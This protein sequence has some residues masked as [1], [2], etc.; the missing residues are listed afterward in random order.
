[1][2]FSPNG[3]LLASAS[4]DHTVRLWDPKTKPWRATLEGHSRAVNAVAFSPN[5]Q[6]LASASNDCTVRLWDSKTGASCAAL[7]GHSDS[8]GA[9]AFS[10]DGQLLASASDDHTV[11]LW[12]IKT[13]DTIQI[14]DVEGHINELS[15]SSDGPYLK[16]NRGVLELSSLLCTPSR[17]QTDHMTHL[18]VTEQWVAWNQNNILWLPPDYRATRVAVQ[19]DVFALGHAS[20]R[21]TFIEF[22]LGEMASSAQ[23]L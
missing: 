16:T 17:P 8:V 6:L 13:R 5:G 12:D 9:V 3:Q 19:N 14:F 4:D 21:V 20:G 23:S 22:D 11:R 10:P 15:F 1:V 2:A 18:Y 7:E